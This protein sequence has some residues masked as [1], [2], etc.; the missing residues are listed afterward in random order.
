M[1]L[2]K[3]NLVRRSYKEYKNFIETDK[4]FKRYVIYSENASYTHFF[5]PLLEYFIKNKVSISF[6]SSDINDKI[7]LIKNDYVKVFFIE[8]DF[9][10]TIFFKNLNCDNIIM[11]MPDLGNYYIK[12]SSLC[13]NY[14][15]MFHTIASSYTIYNEN[16]F[17]NY[18]HIFCA[19]KHHYDEFIM[20]FRNISKRPKL[21]KVGY[22]KIDE[23]VNLEISKSSKIINKILIAPTWGANS[24][25]NICSKDIIKIL[26]E[27]QYIVTLRPHP[28]SLKT[29]FMIIVSYLSLIIL[30]AVT[31]IKLEGYNKLFIKYN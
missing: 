2:K 6:I 5:N 4:S 28:I 20:R 19:G 14:F 3:I 8:N 24:L 10:R 18:D 16:S 13:K 29:D 11:T 1:F 7:F 30:Y 9:I 25:L 23:L 31:R 17:D 12:K 15:Y 22:S 27:N 21:H 26:I